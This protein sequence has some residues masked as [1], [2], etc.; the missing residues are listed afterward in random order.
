MFN[1]TKKIKELKHRIDLKF[2]VTIRKTTKLCILNDNHW[3]KPHKV[4]VLKLSY[5][6]VIINMLCTSCLDILL[7]LF[8]FFY[9]IRFGKDIYVTYQ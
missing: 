1:A 5:Y 4:L 2:I 3:K 8:I 7:K 6:R 9:Q